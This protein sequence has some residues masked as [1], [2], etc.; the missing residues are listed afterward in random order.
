MRSIAYGALWL[1]VFSIPWEDTIVTRFGAISRITGMLAVGLTLI[2]VVVSGR[3]RRW[4]GFHLIGLLFALWSCGV[5]WFHLNA[6]ILPLRFWTYPQLFLAVLMIWELAPKRQA[7]QALMVAYVLGAMVTAMQILVAYR[8]HG[9][10]MRR[11]SA[12]TSDPNSV[13]MTLALGLPMAWYLA[14]TYRRPLL[15]WVCRAYLPVGLFGLMLTASRGGFVTAMVGLLVVPLTMTKLS[16]GKLAMGIAL[17]ALSGALAVAYVPD[18]IAQ[19]LSTTGSSVEDMNLGG[20]FEIWTAGIK[21]FGHAPLT[22]YG[23]GGFKNA[24]A[25][26]LRGEPRVAHN[27][28]LSV[29][30]E[31]G[32]IGFLLYIT[33]FALVLLGLLKLPALE[34]RYTLV[35]FAAVATAILPLTWEDSKPVWFILA[36]LLGFAQAQAVSAGEYVPQALPQ[37]A[38]SMARAPRAPRPRQPMAAPVRTTDPDATA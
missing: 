4:H 34:R 36:A 14:M 8:T 12:G 35:Q 23:A 13:A 37:R 21:A 31:Q 29:L 17:I 33:M 2:A 20:R 19:R 27:S 11:F 30:V 18:T 38:S 6:P 16:P 1:F 9:G 32:L 26:Y 15:R 7:L 25:P 5:L 3:I 10:V 28:Y 22:G 24:A